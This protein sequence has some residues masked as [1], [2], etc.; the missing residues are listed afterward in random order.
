MFDLWHKWD[1]HDLTSVGGWMVQIV[2]FWYCQI[3]ARTPINTLLIRF[4]IR[5]TSLNVLTSLSGRKGKVPILRLKM[6]MLLCLSKSHTQKQLSFCNMEQ[7]II[8]P[9]L[10]FCYHGYKEECVVNNITHL[11]LL[12]KTWLSDRRDIETCIHE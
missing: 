5:D 9:L 8:L 1:K 2:R 7:I 12:S 3:W 11:D 4:L 6:L 10:P